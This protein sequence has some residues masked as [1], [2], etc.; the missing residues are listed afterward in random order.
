[1]KHP[2]SYQAIF[3]IAMTLI[4]YAAVS[5]S[6][7]DEPTIKTPD[8]FVDK[9]ICSGPLQ[10]SK[11]TYDHENNGG[12]L[13]ILADKAGGRFTVELNPEAKW[14]NSAE[15]KTLNLE[16]RHVHL[17]DFIDESEARPLQIKESEYANWGYDPTAIGNRS[18]Y[19]STD[20]CV[21]Y[22]STSN[23]KGVEAKCWQTKVEY[24][25]SGEEQL[26]MGFA[27]VTTSGLGLEINLEPNTT[28]YI[29]EIKVSAY[30][31]IEEAAAGTIKRTNSHPLTVIIRQDPATK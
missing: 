12:S 3:C 28:D 20:Y 17:C 30:D 9:W 14:S 1:M 25:E 4:C 5:C 23:D 2:N 6:S 19:Y 21:T 10:S 26:Y 13:F 15:N 31:Q 27:K 8:H 24:T 22:I 29:K 18:I 16:N 11:Y 7:N